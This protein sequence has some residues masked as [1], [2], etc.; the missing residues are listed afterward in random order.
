MSSFFDITMDIVIF[1]PLLIWLS[2]PSLAGVT[3]PPWRSLGMQESVS[4]KASSRRAFHALHHPSRRF[5]NFPEFGPSDSPLAI[6][7]GAT[8]AFCD[9]R[10]SNHLCV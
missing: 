5:H 10:E 4:Q 7:S 3:H 8:M 9:G 6:K 1:V 2:S